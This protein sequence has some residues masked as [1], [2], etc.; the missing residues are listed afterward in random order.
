MF[1]DQDEAQERMDAE[2]IKI[3]RPKVCITDEPV[4]HIT[5]QPNKLL[6]T[7]IPRCA[8]ALNQLED[9]IGAMRRGAYVEAA[10]CMGLAKEHLI[11]EEKCF[12]QSVHIEIKRLLAENNSMYEELKGRDFDDRFDQ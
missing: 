6:G 8:L 11:A 9:A 7:G 10:I 1:E 2:A 4:E 12:E 3:L 5:G